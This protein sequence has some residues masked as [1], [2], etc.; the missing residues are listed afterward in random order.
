MSVLEEVAQ[1]AVVWKSF[2]EIQLTWKMYV[3]IYNLTF[4]TKILKLF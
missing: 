2:A 4:K 3:C 1:K